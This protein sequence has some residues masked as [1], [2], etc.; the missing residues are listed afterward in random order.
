M[1]GSGQRVA[2]ERWGLYI[3][4]DAALLA[5]CAAV[6][7]AT[8]PASQ[9]EP[10]PVV[11]AE[12]SPPPRPATIA[13]RIQQDGWITRFW[14]QL[15][16]GQRRRVTALFRR[17]DPPLAETEEEAAPVWDTLGLTDRDSLI[18]GPGLS[19]RAVP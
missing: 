17:N 14:E 3:L 4:I 19:A 7:V 15:T 6:E 10:I 8:E 16:P 9:P 5:G 11:A 12:P 13:E 18:F 2:M 1:R